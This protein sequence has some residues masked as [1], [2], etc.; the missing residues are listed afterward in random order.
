MKIQAELPGASSY[1]LES[2]SKRTTIRLIGR[3]QSEHVGGQANSRTHE[4]GATE[5]W[6]LASLAPRMCLSWTK[7]SRFT[8]GEEQ[9]FS[10][11]RLFPLTFAE[12]CLVQTHDPPLAAFAADELCRAGKRFEAAVKSL[13]GSKTVAF[14]MSL[15]V[16][17][18]QFPS[19]EPGVFIRASA[20]R[21]SRSCR[22]TMASAA[23]EVHACCSNSIAMSLPSS[24]RCRK[25]RTVLRCSPGK[26]SYHPRVVL[27]S[28]VPV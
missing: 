14:S 24:F 12:D 23:A 6:I 8:A 16:R 1:N 28:W 10:H 25:R 18:H 5:H 9:V 11:S 17:Q 2:P 26:A 13:N 21:F 20:P 3:F 15:V 7:I 27:L 19:E 22:G 4:C